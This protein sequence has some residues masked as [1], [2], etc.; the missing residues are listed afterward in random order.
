MIMVILLVLF[1]LFD[2]EVFYVIFYLIVLDCYDSGAFIFCPLNYAGLKLRDYQLFGV[3]WFYN[4]YNAS[5]GAILCDEMGLGKTCQ[6][7]IKKMTCDFYFDLEN[8][9]FFTDDQLPFCSKLRGK[10]GQETTAPGCVSF[11]SRQQL[12]QRI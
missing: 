4:R 7:R 9:V 2:D 5:L 11:V 10:S 1:H 8:R 3:N 6:V 12:D